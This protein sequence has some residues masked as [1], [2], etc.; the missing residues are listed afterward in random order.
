[1]AIAAIDSSV[2]AS[3]CA[4]VERNCCP[5]AFSCSCFTCSSGAADIVQLHMYRCYDAKFVEEMQALE[6]LACR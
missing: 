6:K 3:S 2:L 5:Q 1:M 4:T